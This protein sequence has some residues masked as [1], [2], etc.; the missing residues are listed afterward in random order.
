MSNRSVVLLPR[1]PDDVVALAREL[2]PDG[3]VIEV[4]DLDHDR[5]AA[6]DAL[7]RADFVMG[8]PYHLDRE[9]FEAARGSVRL[10]QLL[11]AGFDEIDVNLSAEH[12]IP[13]ATN[14]GA[15]A[16]A[17]AE[18]AILLILAALKKM[19]SLTRAVLDG[20]WPIP[21]TYSA[22]IFEL[23][24]KTLGL[25]GLGQI[26]KRVAA[27]AQAFGAD[28]IYFDVFRQDA[29][30]EVDLGVAFRKLDDLL[31]QSDVVSLHLP[32]SELTEGMI[33][34]EQFGT[35]KEG[36]VLV[37][38]ARGQLVN[39]TAL[40]AALQS[41]RLRAAA[42]DTLA[43]EPA[44]PATSPLV[45][46]PRVIVT[47]HSAGSTWDSWYARLANAYGN[48]EAVSAGGAPQWKVSP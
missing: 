47:P 17:V 44:S 3:Y 28:V 9:A 10:I 35:I 12:G 22:G 23:R 7:T 26:G 14:G 21:N 16:V 29:A 48:M 40:L 45:G 27:L 4:A 2:A 24:G 5:P 43:E 39:E 13:V 20:D 46:H 30:T 34:E 25:V 19:S 33:G 42:L 38:T 11:S 8:F 18:H 41:G 15:N 37:N 32:L 36:A 6:L 1:L 31:S